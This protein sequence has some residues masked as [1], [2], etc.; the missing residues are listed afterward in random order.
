MPISCAVEQATRLVLKPTVTEP[1]PVAVTSSSYEPLSS[2]NDTTPEAL[3]V[4][5]RTSGKRTA[6]SWLFLSGFTVA[7][8]TLRVSVSWKRT[9]TK[10]GLRGAR[11]IMPSQQCTDEYVMQMKHRLTL[12]HTPAVGVESGREGLSLTT[13]ASSV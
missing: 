4:P 10:E 13:G 12:R 5:D 8:G 11:K 6:K 7:P 9:A 3:V 2:E 1:R